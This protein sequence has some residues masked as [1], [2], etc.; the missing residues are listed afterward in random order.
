MPCTLGFNRSLRIEV[1]CERITGDAGAVTGREVPRRSG[2]VRWMARR[3]RDAREGYR[4]RHTM[5]ELLRTALLLAAQCRRDHNDAGALRGDPALR[6]GVSDRA[7]TAPLGRALASQP[8]LSRVVAA[9]G[10][11][12]NAKVLRDGLAR[13]AG[14][15]IRAMNH[16]RLPKRLVIDLDS[17]PAEV[18]GRQP[19]SEWNGYYRA[20][21]YHPLVASVGETG[22]LLDV[23]LRKGAAHT[24]DGGLGFIAEVLD[25]AERFLCE[26]AMVRFDA[27]YPGEELMAAL[28]ARGTHY[29]ARVRNN[30]VLK[31]LALPAVDALAWEALLAGRPYEGDEPRTWVCEAAEPY[32]AGILVAH[33]AGRAGPGGGARRAVS[34]HVLAADFAFRRP[35]HGR[36]TPGDVPA[37]RQGRGPHG[38]A[39]ERG[40]PGV[41]VVAPSEAPLPRPAGRE[42]GT[43]HRHPSPATR[44]ACFSPSSATRSCT[45]SAPSSN[46]RPAPGGA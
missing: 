37:A 42:S 34:P 20:R 38:R 27:G 26:K 19:G 30:A 23:R 18:H 3:I 6:L 44:R 29:V 2:V 21:V 8:T 12:K 39:D 10:K 43:R 33:P 25:R 45:P 17:L 5:T 32:R 4:I 24:A 46:A 13:L 36:G 1:R 7:G 16:G 40:E 31:R 22:D 14:W 28:E 9:L 11:G 35:G 15:R 41:V